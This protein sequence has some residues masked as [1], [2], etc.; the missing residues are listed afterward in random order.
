MRVLM[1]VG[2]TVEGDVIVIE[3]DGVEGQQPVLRKDI[4]D[5]GGILPDG[6]CLSELYLME[7][8][9]KTRFHHKRIPTTKIES[10]KEPLPVEEPPVTAKKTTRRRRASK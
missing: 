2:K 1:L 10:Q 8:K 7:P 6:T 4:I 9:K 5:A 3:G